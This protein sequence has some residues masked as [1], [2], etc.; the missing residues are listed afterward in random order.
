MENIFMSGNEKTPANFT[1]PDSKIKAGYKVRPSDSFIINTDLQNFAPKEQYV[2]QTITYDIVDGP[3]PD[4][5]SSQTVWLTIGT[6]EN[7]SIGLCH[8][9]NGEF[10][11]SLTNLTS[12]DLPK[13][14]VFSEHS[15]IWRAE[16][17]GLVLVAGG[18]VHAGA[19]NI[20]IFKNHEVFC[21]S[22]ATYSKAISA[23]GSRGGHSHG[24][25]S[26]PG[27]GMT[28]MPGMKKRQVKGGDYSNNDVEFISTI[29]MCNFPEGVPLRI[30]DALH[31]QAN[32]DLNLHKG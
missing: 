2:W 22:V 7:P 10:P 32:Y 20:E 12:K 3:A 4:H 17:A 27:S 25:G 21:D 30:N 24:G 31:I 8:Y 15:K 5:L 1:L 29:S 9:T 6:L 23:D 26:G 28:S 16:G 13:T 11:W 19:T 14:K 18:H